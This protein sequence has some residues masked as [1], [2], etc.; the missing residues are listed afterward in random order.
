[1]KTLA[2]LLST[3]MAG[4]ISYAFPSSSVVA[5]PRP[6]AAAPAAPEEDCTGCQNSTYAHS[7]SGSP[8]CTP[9]VSIT[10]MQQLAGT[11]NLQTCTPATP[12]NFITKSIFGSGCGT[13]YFENTFNATSGLFPPG[14]VHFDN[15]SPAC[16]AQASLIIETADEYRIAQLDLI[17]SACIR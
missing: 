14:S 2:F 11:C 17:C 16:G 4:T 6:L 10:V 7:F 9:N 12:C 8:N 3:A 1:M 15:I 5:A 13:Y